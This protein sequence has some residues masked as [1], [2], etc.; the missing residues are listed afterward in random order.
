MKEI[1]DLTLTKIQDQ[2]SVLLKP[3]L[4]SLGFYGFYLNET[5]SMLSLIEDKDEVAERRRKKF[6]NKKLEEL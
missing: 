3:D 5:E 2:K 1:Q 4:Y 6:Q